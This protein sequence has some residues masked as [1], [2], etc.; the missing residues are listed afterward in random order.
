MREH[1][2]RQRAKER[3]FSQGALV[4]ASRR[5]P[6]AVIGVRF[7]KS[8]RSLRKEGAER[9]NR[10][11]KFP[12]VL[13]AALRGDVVRRFEDREKTTRTFPPLSFAKEPRT[14]PFSGLSEFVRKSCLSQ[15]SIYVR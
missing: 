2:Q 5:N 6:A 1:N 12:S 9:S 15:L 11:V 7:C 3:S 8:L 4:A 14:V 13:T 10:E